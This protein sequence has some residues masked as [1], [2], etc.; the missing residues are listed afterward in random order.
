MVKTNGEDTEK[1]LEDVGDIKTL[2]AI[3]KKNANKILGVLPAG[4]DEDEKKDMVKAMIYLAVKAYEE[5]PVLRNC[6][7][8]SI[9]KAVM[10]AASLGMIPFSLMNECAIIPYGRVAQ[11]QLMY[12]GVYKLANNTGMFKN[13]RVD[14][15]REED[16]FHYEKSF[17]VKLIHIPS[18]KPIADRDIIFFYGLYELKD[19]GKDFVIMTRNDMDAHRD[20]YSK[21]YRKAKSNKKLVTAVWHNEYEAMGLK[22][23]LIKLLK[24]APKSEKL[25]KQL[26]LD[27]VIKREIAPEPKDF[28]SEAEEDFIMERQADVE[29]SGVYDESKSKKKKSKKKEEAKGDKVTE[30]DLDKIFKLGKQLKLSKNTLINKIKIKFKLNN[31][32]NISVS[33]KEEVEKELME[34]IK[35]TDKDKKEEKK[36]EGKE[37]TAEDIN[38]KFEE[39]EKQEKAEQE[40]LI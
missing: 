26:A 40:K 22:T 33:Q 31:V 6:T 38:K 7:P 35:A 14:V 2:P 39:K 19:G 9:L 13:I 12:R 36:E 27:K 16:K 23:I 8:D 17:D 20:R 1:N 11:F 34:A 29:G 32:E 37:E 30:K 24:Y 18:Q 28:T 21:Q 3:L 25:V 5:M 4:F 15:V 10:E